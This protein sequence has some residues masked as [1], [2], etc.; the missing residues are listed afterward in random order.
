MKEAANLSHGWSDASSHIQRELRALRDAFDAAWAV[1]WGPIPITREMPFVCVLFEDRDPLRARCSALG[2]A[3]PLVGNPWATCILEQDFCLAE[4]AA[5]DPRL[6]LHASVIARNHIV[7]IASAAFR[8]G[9]QCWGVAEVYGTAPLRLPDDP[10][11]VLRRA[12]ERV[13]DVVA[14]SPRPS[15]AELA[16]PARDPI[17]AAALHDLKSAL[18][19]QT[20][21]V[22]SF[23]KELRAAASGNA[24]TD[25]ARLASMLESLAVLRESVAHANELARVMTLSQLAPGTRVAIDLR[26]L[27]RLALAAVPP[28]LRARF[29]IEAAPEFSE[30]GSVS[31][32]PGLL[33]A[34]HNL[35]QNAA[36]AIQ[37][38][39]EARAIIRLRTEGEN[40]LIE[41]QDEGPGVPPEILGKLFQ[42]GTT[43]RAQP[44]GH[45][46]GLY[47]ARNSV[48]A[49]G[50]SLTLYSVP[51]RGACFTIRLPSTVAGL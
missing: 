21:L 9:G 8:R 10:A 50:G 6:S 28:E 48:E 51:Q 15:A 7:A 20:L 41:V 14:A 25:R 12:A 31:D 27:V 1:I 46:F 23:E 35:V 43:T 5:H 39:P 30:A 13:A 19:A 18:A 26:G 42:P 36:A 34:V 2:M 11:G 24:D 16:P 37:C 32:A 17:T 33:R 22:T 44:Q 38:V 47:S 45:G 4:N 29:D 40:V 49:L 3:V